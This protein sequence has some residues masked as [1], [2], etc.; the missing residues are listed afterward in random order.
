MR[1][2][3]LK[4]PGGHGYRGRAPTAKPR[5]ATLKADR[6]DGDYDLDRM[7]GASRHVVV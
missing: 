2:E 5:D 1:E 7:G 4:H 6:D 3:N